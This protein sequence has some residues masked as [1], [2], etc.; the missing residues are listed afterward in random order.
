L[1]LNELLKKPKNSTI[2]RKKKSNYVWNKLLP[3]FRGEG[4]KSGGRASQRRDQTV[5]KTY[6]FGSIQPVRMVSS[7]FIDKK[8]FCNGKPLLL[9]VFQNIELIERLIERFY[10]RLW[11]V[12]Y[13]R[14][15]ELLMY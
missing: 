6:R 10:N 7:K 14:L 5:T 15:L 11:F 9:L 1:K 12:S 3:L 13:A 8:L 2:W 4:V